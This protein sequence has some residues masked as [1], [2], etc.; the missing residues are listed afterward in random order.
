M[1]FIEKNGIK[2]DSKIIEFINLEAI[3]GTNI[4]VD[5]F[6]K[7]FSEI[8]LELAPV[9]QKLIKKREVIQKKLDD[10][11]KSNNHK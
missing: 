1:S 5:S 4:K 7:S 11:H 9:N 10:W 2:I 8:A 6:W 3:P